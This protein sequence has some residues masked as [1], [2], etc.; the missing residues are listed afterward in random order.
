[1]RDLIS[2]LNISKALVMKGVSLVVVFA[3]L[4]T[5]YVAFSMNKTLGWFAKN[6]TVTASGMITQAYHDKFN[7]E[8]SLDGTT[9]Q[10]F[11]GTVDLT[12]IKAPGDTIQI[13]FRVR[14]I[15]SKPVTLTGFGLDAPGIN[16]DIPRF[17]GGTAYYLS[18][19]LRTRLVSMKVGE[20]AITISNDKQTEESLTPLRTDTGANAISYFEWIDAANRQIAMQQNDF[21]V[22][23]VEFN[24]INRMTV[25]Q[26]IYKN[27][28]ENGGVCIR[29]V[30]ITFE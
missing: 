16:D 8:Y 9:W 21:V 7:V 19:E 12:N 3:M 13:S 29:D 26:N 30:Y 15:G 5:A 28:Q 2:K 11:T 23:T 17:D 22:F 10:A 24:F 1:M 4:I 27:Y 20:T 18:T 6:N 14:S 25:N